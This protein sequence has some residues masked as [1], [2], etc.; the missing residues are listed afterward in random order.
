[1][2]VD[3]LTFDFGSE[4]A[5]RLKAQGSGPLRLAVA[6]RHVSSSSHQA[7]ETTG[8]ERLGFWRLKVNDVIAANR[9]DAAIERHELSAVTSSQSKQVAVGDLLAGLSGAHFRHP[10]R[11]RRIRPEFMHPAVGREQQ[12]LIRRPLDGPPAAGQLR[13]DSD[14]TELRHRAG[15]PR[16]IRVG[17][18]PAQS[19]VVMLVLGRRRSPPAR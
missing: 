13:T 12:Q 17:C 9:R 7:Q 8:R 14:N 18:V 1:M 16:L 2:A 4:E 15:G 10:G 6:N 11:R 3:L 19:D 5:E